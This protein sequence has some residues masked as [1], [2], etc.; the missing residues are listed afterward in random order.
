[1]FSEVVS[2]LSMKSRCH[3]E[4]GQKIVAGSS[5]PSKI[6][7]NPDNCAVLTE[8]IEELDRVVVV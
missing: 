5:D 7:N 1:M 2:P 4:I 3:A 8:S 6:G